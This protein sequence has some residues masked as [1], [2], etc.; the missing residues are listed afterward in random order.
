MHRK[1]NVSLIYAQKEK[2]SLIY[3]QKEKF[4]LIY[5]QKE[6]IS[7]IY[8]QK[9]INAQNRKSFINLCKERKRF[10]FMQRKKSFP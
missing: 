6:N 8:A 2:F 5:A 10:K 3:A 7:L 4:S 9:E 1:K